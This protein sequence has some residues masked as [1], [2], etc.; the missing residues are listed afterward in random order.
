[1]FKRSPSVPKKRPYK[2]TMQCPAAMLVTLQ[3]AICWRHPKRRCAYKKMV[4]CPAA[5]LVALNTTI[6][7]AKQHVVRLCRLLMSSNIG[8]H[9][10]GRKPCDARQHFIQ[11]NRM[12]NK[13]TFRS[14]CSLL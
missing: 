12:A 5:M 10:I 8:K 14:L 13:T 6:R 3:S 2:K 1:V 9:G 11:I 7:R 4:E